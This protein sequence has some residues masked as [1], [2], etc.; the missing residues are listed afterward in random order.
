MKGILIGF[1]AHSCLFDLSCAAHSDNVFKALMTSIVCLFLLY[2]NASR[3]CKKLNWHKTMLS[4]AKVVSYVST[5]HYR[6]LPLASYG[7]QIRLWIV[8]SVTPTLVPR[9]AHD[10]CCVTCL[11]T[12]SLVNG[13]KREMLLVQRKQ[14][15]NDMEQSVVQSVLAVNMWK[16]PW[17]R[18]LTLKVYVF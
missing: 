17:E 14:G 8:L 6:N 13:N 5:F 2:R 4:P 12:H 11:S 15:V 16:C 3:K 1:S 7:E 18:Y 10:G 9:A